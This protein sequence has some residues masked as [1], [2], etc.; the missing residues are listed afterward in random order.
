M[1]AFGG[2]VCL[3]FA[4]GG[5]GGDRVAVSVGI[6]VGFGASIYASIC[7]SIGASIG[8]FV[9]LALASIHSWRRHR[10]RWAVLCCRG[11]DARHGQVVFG[12]AG[13]EGV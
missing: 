10:T 11:I 1:F 2:A 13:D 5:R 4:V 8:L 7:A 6:S 3:W 9:Y 12:G